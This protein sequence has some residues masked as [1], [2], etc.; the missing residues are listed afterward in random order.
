MSSNLLTA[1][2]GHRI[3]LPGHFDVPVVL[4]DARPLGLDDSAGYECRVRLPDGSLEEA[5]ISADEVPAITRAAP[6]APESAKPV[7]AEK[8]RLLVESARIRLAYAHDAQFAVSVS[9]I[10]TL[11]HQIEAVY[12]AML[13]PIAW[14][15]VFSLLMILVPVRL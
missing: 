2:I 10:R 12:Q 4:E 1:H 6:A 14:E 11:P 15:A 5:V 7:D 9:G 3:S 8:L 13:P